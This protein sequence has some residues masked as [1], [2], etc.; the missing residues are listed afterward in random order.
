MAFVYVADW[1]GS[2]GCNN[3][4]VLFSFGAL[5]KVTKPTCR[6]VSSARH[7]VLLCRTYVTIMTT[8]LLSVCLSV[9]L[10]VYNIGRLIT[11]CK[12]VEIG[13]W[14]NRL[15]GVLVTCMPKP[16]QIMLC[17]DTEFYYGKP[18]GY[19]K[20]WSFALQWQLSTVCMLCYFSICWPSWLFFVLP[21]QMVL[22]C[23]VCVLC[24]VSSIQA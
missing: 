13:T 3:R 11:Y 17:C 15:V 24:L 9:C 14:Q 10:S 22:A 2:Y 12:K 5:Y 23:L 1:C 16:T 6:L 19:G 7:A 21:Y 18:V 20:V 4:P 8:I